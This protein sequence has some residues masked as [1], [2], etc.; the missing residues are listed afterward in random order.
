M[1]INFALCLLFRDY[2]LNKITRRM[3]VCDN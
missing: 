1:L 3:R 2:L